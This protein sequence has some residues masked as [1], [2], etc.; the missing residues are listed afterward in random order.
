MAES[1]VCIEVR[2]T[3]RGIAE[4]DIARI[5]EPFFTTKGP[6]EGTGLGLHLCHQIISSLGGEMSVRSTVG[7]GTCFS[8]VL[9]SAPAKAV[10]ASADSLP[11]SRVTRI[12]RILVIDD[13]L[14]I[15]R[16]FESLLQDHE[17]ELAGSGREGIERLRDVDY[18]VVFCDVSMPDLTG[19]DVYEF[20]RAEKPGREAAL[21]FMTGGAF[22]ERTLDFL[23][24][25]PNRVLCK[26]FS[27]EAIESCLPC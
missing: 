24:T 13:E 9:P 21:V 15:R 1:R 10:P 2:D 3:G 17:V 14:L 7:E 20:L 12:C 27:F 25:V 4:E 16:T 5:F 8:I 26:P 11:G 22:K 23:Q 19:M 18:D 6:H